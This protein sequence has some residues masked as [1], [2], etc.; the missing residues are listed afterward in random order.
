MIAGAY[1]ISS[2]LVENGYWFF[3]F[4]PIAFYFMIHKKNQDKIRVGDFLKKDFTTMNYTISSERPLTFK[5][6][7]EN[8]EL[9]GPFIAVNGIPIN[10]IR[11]KNQMKRHFVVRNEKNHDFELIVEVVQTW[12][13]RILYNISST[14]RIRN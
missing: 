4:I 11:Y 14:S 6:K 8:F 5:E 7:F 3:V 12:R 2:F 9:G 10:A 13:N 1:L